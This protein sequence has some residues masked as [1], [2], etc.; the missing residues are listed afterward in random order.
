MNIYKVDDILNNLEN[1]IE[2]K[3]PFSHIRFGDGGIKFIDAILTG[4]IEQLNI[5]NRKEGLPPNKIIAIFELWGYYARQADYIDTPEVYFNNTFWPRVKKPGKEINETTKTKMLNWKQLYLNAEFDNENYCNPESNYLMI[6]RR[7]GFKNIFDIM[8]DRK[9][10]LITAVPEVKT[11]LYEYNIDI[12]TIVKHYQNQY[13]NSYKKVMD[14]IKN[15]A[16]NYDFFIVAAGELGRIYTGY[17]KEN[18]GRAVDLGFTIEYW[19]HQYLHPRLKYY[20]T[21]NI[22]NKLELVLTPEGKKY[23]EWI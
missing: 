1:C 15:Q 5:I 4:N 11:A 8:K 7:S 21:P 19:H 20:M 9:I 13:K 3:K 14:F 17:I 16:M 10:A 23:E 2:Y 18:G 22:N 6:L 12:I